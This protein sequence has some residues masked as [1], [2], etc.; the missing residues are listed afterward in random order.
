[1]VVCIDSFVYYGTDDLY[2]NYLAR[3]LK[4]GGVLG[5]AGAGLMQE[6]DVAVPDHLKAWWEP[7]LAAFI[8]PGGGVG[9]RSGQASSIS[10]WPI[11]FRTV[12]NSGRT[13]N[14]WSHLTIRWRSRLSKQTEELSSVTSASW[15]VDGPR[16][17]WTNRS[18]PSQRVHEGPLAT[19][20]EERLLLPNRGSQPTAAGCVSR[21][22]GSRSR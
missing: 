10:T 17:A 22:G 13:G 9:T 15:V 8:P 20:S 21:R 6:I 3:F 1:M 7:R 12:G 19:S 16:H 18:C 14:A 11:P 4:P 5:V 2:L